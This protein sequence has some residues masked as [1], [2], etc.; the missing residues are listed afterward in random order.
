MLGERRKARALALQALYEIDSTGH[1]AEKVVSYLLAE[2]NLSEVNADF[3]RAMVTGVI[4][5]KETTTA[6]PTRIVIIFPADF[7]KPDLDSWRFASEWRF[8]VK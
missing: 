3:V 1:D 8:F 7:K 2:E 4:Q 5:N 6:V